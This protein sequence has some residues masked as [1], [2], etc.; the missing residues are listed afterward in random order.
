MENENIDV[1]EQLKTAIA[2]II[3][4]QK[5][6]A[7]EITSIKTDLMDN[8][9]NP[10][11]GEF[12]KYQ[13]DEALSDFRE[14][15]AEKFE[16]LNTDVLKELEHNPDFD[17]VEKAF[18]GYQERTDGM[19]EE[20]YVEK[21]ANHIQ[22]QLNKL[23]K[24][25]GVEPEKIEE[26]K[27]ETTDGEEVKAEVEDGQVVEVEK[28]TEVEEKVEDITTDETKEEESTADVEE[29]SANAESSNAETEEELSEE[30]ENARHMAELEEEKKR[31]GIE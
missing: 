5:H 1:I 23:G 8:L 4:Y 14:K 12:E 31:E 21:F 26:V 9:I 7:E 28:E 6:L 17:I 25:F 13:H 11:K 18:D 29:T 30:E 19:G 3:E 20:E 15:Y 2:D 10:I 16:G 27:V 24:A 22:E